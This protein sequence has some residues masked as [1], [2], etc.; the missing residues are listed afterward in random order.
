MNSCKKEWG[1]THQFISIPL[2]LCMA[3]YTPPATP[4]T[5]QKKHPRIF[6]VH[7]SHLHNTKKC[8]INEL[9]S[10][11]IRVHIIYELMYKRMAFHIP[12]FHPLITLHGIIHS[13]SHTS[14]HPKKPSTNIYCSYCSPTQHKKNTKDSW[15]R[16]HVPL[17]PMPGCVLSKEHS[18]DWKTKSGASS[19]SAA[20]LKGL[21]VCKLWA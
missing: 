15:H 17:V 9:N 6:T 20:H 18:K 2:S 16:K 11:N 7:I 5:A 14:Y 19:V 4:A 10:F 13:S 8:C 12:L 21:S 1:S 3:S